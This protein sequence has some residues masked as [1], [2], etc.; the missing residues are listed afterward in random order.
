MK[1]ISI[2]IL[3]VI[4]ISGWSLVA[5]N[6]SL[7]ETSKPFDH[8]NC[9][10]PYRWSNPVDGCDNSD[11]AV[12]ECMKASMTQETEKQCIDSFVKQHEQP[13]PSQTPQ[14]PAVEPIVASVKICK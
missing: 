12:P 14:E 2:I 8:S 11:P 13:A 7:A 6:T 3:F 10:Y 4:A 1:R 9:Q 5:L